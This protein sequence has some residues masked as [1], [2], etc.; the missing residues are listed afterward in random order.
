MTDIL[1]RLAALTRL[2]RYAEIS[3][4]VQ[5]RV[6]EGR[7][8]M[9]SRRVQ[10]AVA[11]VTAYCLLLGVCGSGN[12]YAWPSF[13]PQAF[14]KDQQSVL[15]AVADQKAADTG[16]VCAMFELGIL[17][18]RGEGVPQSY[19]DAFR[20]YSAASQK[21]YDPAKLALGI[22]YH[23]GWGVSQDSA[24]ASA[25]YAS[26]EKSEVPEISRAAKELGLLLHGVGTQVA[27]GGLS[28]DHEGNFTGCANAP[29]SSSETRKAPDGFPYGTAENRNQRQF[30]GAVE[31]FSSALPRILQCST[32]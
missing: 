2:V 25:F 4:G 12:A 1:Q 15:Q 22:L 5:Y 19:S 28:A 9:S 27:P 8:G 14:E 23:N 17:Y 21:G 32:A 18:Q 29:T 30:T 11:L 10:K 20:W 31:S 16:D 24:K 13:S 6:W 7:R 3:Q 26:A